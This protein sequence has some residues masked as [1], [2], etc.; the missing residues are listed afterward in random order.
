[1]TR[2]WERYATEAVRRD[3]VKEPEQVV[4]EGYRAEFYVLFPQCL[5]S[6]DC[7]AVRWRGY[8]CMAL[9]RIGAPEARRALDTLAVDPGAPR[10]VRYGSVV[11]LGFIGSPESL[12]A[13]RKVADGDII[14]MIRW[15]AKQALADM[16]LAQRIAGGRAR[17]RSAP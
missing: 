9:G 6:D 5:A 2:E 14:W 16:E 4:A 11:G 1:M 15:T 17:D 8:L 10:D 3:P 7:N 12:P 13:L